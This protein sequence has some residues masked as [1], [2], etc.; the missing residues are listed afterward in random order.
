[1]KIVSQRALAGAL[2]VAAC[3]VPVDIVPGE[4][5]QIVSPDAGFSLGGGGMGGESGLGGGG[6]GL[7]GGSG[8]G[9]AL[10]GAPGTGGTGFTQGGTGGVASMGGSAGMGG[11][12]LGTGGAGG[13]GMGGAGVEPPPENCVETGSV[14]GFNTEVFYTEN[15]QNQSIGMT[16]AIRN[17]GAAF[18]MNQLS[19]RYW[20]TPGT[21]QAFTF[22]CYYAQSA[23]NATITDDVSVTFGQNAVS[24]FA[25][26]TID[27]A[28]PMGTG[29]NQIQLDLRAN[30]VN[31]LHTDDFSFVDGA[32]TALNPNISAYVDGV[33]VFGCE[34]PD[35]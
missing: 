12:M 10:G 14:G 1:M 30:N 15:V 31:L 29:I 21:T 18:N 20:Y 23:A 22:M 11:S 9:G 19:V 16:L 6:T 25:E 3:A 4:D 8:T 5:V 27:R 32:M 26:V 35:L 33:Q 13:A 24:A 17:T 2:L 7:V 34:P 28:D